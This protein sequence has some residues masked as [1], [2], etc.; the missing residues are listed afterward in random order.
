MFTSRYFAPFLDVLTSNNKPFDM[1]F[2]FFSLFFWSWKIVRYGQFPTT[3]LLRTHLICSYPPWYCLQASFIQTKWVS[4]GYNRRRTIFHFWKHLDRK[5]GLSF[6]SFL[7]ARYCPKDL[8]WTIGIG[9]WFDSICER[10]R[11]I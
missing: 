5:G 4:C 2:L 1:I 7:S 3:S 6:S 10:S 11:W 8:M 9:G